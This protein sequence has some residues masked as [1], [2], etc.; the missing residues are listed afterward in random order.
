MISG[1]FGTGSNFINGWG[2][3]GNLPPSILAANGY[4]IRNYLESLNGAGMN[5]GACSNLSGPTPCTG[6][7]IMYPNL[8]NTQ[9]ITENTVAP[10]L[11]LSSTVKIADLPLKINVGARYENTHVTSAGLSSLPTGALFILTTDVTAYGFNSTPRS[12]SAPRATTAICC[13]TST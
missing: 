10:Y 12:R 4:A 5:V 3:G 9:D 1:S 6:Q 11:N 7:Y 13:R 8:G 2:N